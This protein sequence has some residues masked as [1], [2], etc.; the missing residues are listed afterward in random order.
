M[1][2]RH[3][4]EAHAGRREGVRGGGVVA[5]ER[6]RGGIRAVEDLGRVRRR[7]VAGGKFRLVLL[8][9]IGRVELVYR[10]AETLAF[11]GEVARVALERVKFRAEV[12]E[13]AP[14]RTV[15]GSVDLAVGVEQT[16]LERLFKKRLVVVRAVD[17]HEE[18]SERAQGLHGR[19]GVVHVDASAACCRNGT[20]HHERA[21]LAGREPRVVE[22]ARHVGAHL[23]VGKREL[24][25]HAR[26]LRAVAH[27]GGVRPRAEDELKRAH[28]DALARA[29][30]AGDDVQPF[31]ERDVSR[32]D[33]GEVADCETG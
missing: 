3:L 31:A 21:V 12:A 18:A 14:C 33:D 19:G 20:P 5:G 6:G 9:Q 2:L 22:N 16:A 15:R 28:E 8:A 11:L 10:V 26:L 29:G 27:R 24:G 25:L 1:V 23:R 32:F 30:F 7:R 4:G 13:I 17:V